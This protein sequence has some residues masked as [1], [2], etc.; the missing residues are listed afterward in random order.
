MT[1]KPDLYPLVFTCNGTN[2]SGVNGPGGGLNHHNNNNNGGFGKNGTGYLMVHYFRNYI[3]RPVGSLSATSTV[4]SLSSSFICTVNEANTIVPPPYSRAASPG[5]NS[6]ERL[7]SGQQQQVSTEDFNPVSRSHSVQQERSTNEDH[8]MHHHHHQHSEDYYRSAEGHPAI[9]GRSLSA[10]L[11]DEQIVMGMQRLE[12]QANYNHHQQ[13]QQRRRTT[14]GDN[15][16]LTTVGPRDWGNGCYA[17]VDCSTGCGRERYHNQ[18][19]QQ[20]MQRQSVTGSGGGGGGSFMNVDVVVER[21]TGNNGNRQPEMKT[22]TCNNNNINNNCH[23]TAGNYHN[24]HKTSPL[25]VSAGYSKSTSMEEAAPAG[26]GGP[27]GGGS[28]NIVNSNNYNNN[29]KSTVCY[30]RSEFELRKLRSSLKTS[31][32]GGA[33]RSA[34]DRELAVARGRSLEEPTNEGNGLLMGYYKQQRGEEVQGLSEYYPPGLMAV[35]SPQQKQQQIRPNS[36]VV[37]RASSYHHNSSLNSSYGD[38]DNDADDDLMEGGNAQMDRLTEELNDLFSGVERV[39]K[40]GKRR[41]SSG[42][43]RSFDAHSEETVEMVNLRWSNEEEPVNTVTSPTNDENNS[44]GQFMDGMLGK[45]FSDLRLDLSIRGRLIQREMSGEQDQSLSTSRRDYMVSPPLMAPG[46][47]KSSLNGISNSAASNPFDHHHLVYMNSSNTG[48]AV[49]SLVNMDCT[50]SS[51]PQATSPT[52]EMRELLEQISQ[53]QMGEGG[54]EEKEGENEEDDDD[55]DR[56]IQRLQRE[57]SCSSSLATENKS[58]NNPNRNNN[59]YKATTTATSDTRNRN[60]KSTK[61]PLSFQ[62]NRHLS[63]NLSSLLLLGDKDEGHEL[64]LHRT[65]LSAVGTSFSSRGETREFRMAEKAVVT[66]E[67]EEKMAFGSGLRGTGMHNNSGSGGSGKPNKSF[68]LPVATQSPTQPIMEMRS[69]MEGY[70]RGVRRVLGNQP[71]AGFSPT[72]GGLFP[73]IL[74]LGQGRR[75]GRLS[76][77]APTTPGTALPPNRFDDV[78]PLLLDEQE[79]EEEEGEGDNV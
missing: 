68:Y 45:S 69:P 47:H 75:F 8:E 44:N 78:S 62:N 36:C 28:C 27:V 64:N 70:G 56:I 2:D 43:R 19:Q 57:G 15:G 79:E 30:S 63:G 25:R 41:K 34:E 5:L 9:T 49:S 4:D 35:Q 55:E 67:G 3:V 40:E 73:G 7:E 24:S 48:S 74:L 58:S 72:S 50:P 77:S 12:E 16:S 65:A 31:G 18:Q 6:T 1:S 38:N 33:G 26:W 11:V 42:E 37:V 52:D 23:S 71:L 39:L 46:H 66:E 10:P 59:N 17:N 53:L 61:R 14:S 60:N 22:S 32:R 51:P 20:Q 21:T 76:R 29:N 13:L 54:R